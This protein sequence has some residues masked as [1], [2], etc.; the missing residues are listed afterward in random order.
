MNTVNTVKEAFK[1]TNQLG[2]VQEWY[3][4]MNPL[5]LLGVLAFLGVPTAFQEKSMGVRTHPGAN[6]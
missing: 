2:D 5:V 1:T 4:H 3:S 6:I